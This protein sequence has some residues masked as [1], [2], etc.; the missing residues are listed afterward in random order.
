MATASRPSWPLLI[1][2]GSGKVLAS[3]VTVEKNL[4][5]SNNVRAEGPAAHMPEG[6]NYQVCYLLEPHNLTYER[7]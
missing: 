4:C 7:S 1:A 3:R 5:F 2:G 6:H